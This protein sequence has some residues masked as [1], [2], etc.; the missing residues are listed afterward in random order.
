[1]YCIIITKANVTWRNMII[2]PNQA[3][4]VVAL[5]SVA[6]ISTPRFC[7]KTTIIVDTSVRWV[8]KKNNKFV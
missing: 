5:T 8:P 2:A 7:F 4:S 6:Q 1:M 3:V